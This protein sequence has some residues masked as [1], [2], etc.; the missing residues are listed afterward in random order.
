MHFYDIQLDIQRGCGFPNR[1]Q[2]NSSGVGIP[3]C[4]G[5]R[6]LWIALEQ[7][8]YPLRREVGKV[9][10][11]ASDVASRSRKG[12]YHTC[13]NRVGFKIDRDNRNGAR[14]RSSRVQ[15]QSAA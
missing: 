6:E 10:E 14:S 1:V 13:G 3:Q 7:H 11:Y 4:G 9:K 2:L 8:L 15:Y 12:S 5:A